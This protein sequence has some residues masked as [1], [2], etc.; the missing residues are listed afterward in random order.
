VA[1]F[2]EKVRSGQWKGATG[3]T[4]TSVV[5]VGI[6]GS[7]KPNQHFMLPRTGLM[8]FFVFLLLM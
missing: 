6:G 4:L 8:V 1:A 3:K 2:S 5:A 7:C